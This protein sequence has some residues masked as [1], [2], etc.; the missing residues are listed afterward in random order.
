MCLVHSKFTN[1]NFFMSMSIPELLINDGFIT[2]GD[3]EKIEST[4]S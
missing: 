4:L 1:I 2:A 3:R